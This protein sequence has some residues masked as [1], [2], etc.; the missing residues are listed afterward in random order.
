MRPIMAPIA[1]TSNVTYAVSNLSNP[2]I[3]KNIARK[4]YGVFSRESAS[5]RLVILTVLLKLKKFSTSQ[6]VV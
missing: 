2:N 5:T 1:M 6:A 4:N 3:S